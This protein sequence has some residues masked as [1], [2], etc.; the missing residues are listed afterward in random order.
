MKD[1]I[2]FTNRYGQDLS[3]RMD[4]PAD[5]APAGY[6]LLAHCFTCSKDLSSLRR[7]SR[8]LTGFGFGVMSFDFTG[9]GHSKGDFSSTGFSSQVTDLIDAAAWLADKYM[10]PIVLVGHSLGGTAALY[11]ARELPSVLGVATIG[12]PSSPDH[13]EN[14]FKSDIAVIQSSG[15]AVVSIGG[16]PFTIKKSFLEDIRRHPP[17]EWLNDLKKEIMILHSP[18]DI[19]VG[20]ENAERIFKSVKH[21]K[22]FV[23]LKDSDHLFS[24]PEDALYAGRIIGGWAES[25]I[26]AAESEQLYTDRQVAARIGRDAYTV[27]IR[28]GRH[29]MTADEP[30]NVGGKNFGPGPYEYLLAG[31]GACTVMT[32]RMYADRKNLP[33]D[34]VTVHLTH[35]KIHAED[36]GACESGPGGM[37]D[38]IERILVID[39]DLSKKQRQRLAEIAD[40]C[41]VHRT[42]TSSVIVDTILR[43][44]I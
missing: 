33:M 38:R 4:L 11:A 9:L 7:L 37:L 34:A 3:A 6:I 18:T 27:D 28:A 10:A 24:R 22:S 40:R 17:E 39:G 42:L 25:F 8:S 2:T 41:P 36:C 14:L 43:E 30:E 12:S 1:E 29:F 31:L 44:T 23:S 32:L 20:I 15:E 21:P 16:R 13:I 19:V 26:P 35:Q 5:A